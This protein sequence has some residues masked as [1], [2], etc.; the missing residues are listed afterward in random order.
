MQRLRLPHYHHGT[1]VSGI[2]RDATRLA[3]RGTV[4][5][6]VTR[7]GQQGKVLNIEALILPKLTSDLPSHPVPFDS[8]WR[9]LLNL[10][11]ADPY[12]GTPGSVDVLLGADVFSRAV[13]NGRRF[14]PSRSPSAFRTHFG[15]VLA[16]TVRDKCDHQKSTDTCCHPTT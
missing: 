7:V 8:K 4:R 15:W 1:K 13:F 11:L 14:R 2:G 5:F 12:F 3:P 6:S 16:G 10:T 9:H